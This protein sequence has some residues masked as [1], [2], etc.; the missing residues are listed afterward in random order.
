MQKLAILGGSHLA[1]LV[2]HQVNLGGKYKVY[3]IY[4]DFG[5]VGSLVAEI[6]IK[7][8]I[9]DVLIDYK[10]NK[11]DLLFVAV[12]YSR[13]DYRESV[14]NKFKGKIPYANIIHKSCIVD[15]TVKIGEGVFL[16][17]GVLLD[18][19][20]VLDDNVLLNVGVT[21]AHDS[22]IRRHCF[23]GPRVSVA[24]FSEFGMKCYL[25]TNATVINNLKISKS[26]IIGAG[27]VVTKNILESGLYVGVPAKK[28]K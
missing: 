3:A 18:K 26:T 27:A 12:G 20:V 6:P 16:F 13:M 2:I 19:G 4:D 5:D 22:I 10:E 14:F 23:F 9:D 17:P 15:P 25:G 21:I 28:V 24:G 7:G 8:K 11:F 1:Q